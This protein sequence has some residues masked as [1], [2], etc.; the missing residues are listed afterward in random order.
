MAC[1][2]FANRSVT[3]LSLHFCMDQT[4]AHTHQSSRKP[5]QVTGRTIPTTSISSF[6]PLRCKV[7]DRRDDGGRSRIVH[8][9][10]R[11]KESRGVKAGV[12]C[13][14]RLSLSFLSPRSLPQCIYP[15]LFFTQQL[16][17]AQ[18]FRIQ[19]AV[20][21]VDTSYFCRPIHTP[22]N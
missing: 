20:D 15:K 6:S 8:T 11:P 14:F 9:V 17:S 10:E 4:K 16:F 1:A 5:N 2:R 21:T 18:V 3:L 7:F 12:I 13:Y 22:P 19:M